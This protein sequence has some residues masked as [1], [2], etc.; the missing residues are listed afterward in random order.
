MLKAVIFDMDGVIAL[1][2]KLH[3]L[4]MKNM[5][6]ELYKIN[7]DENFFNTFIGKSE[8]DTWKGILDKYRIRAHISDLM[9]TRVMYIISEIDKSIVPSSGLIPLLDDLCRHNIII[10]LASSTERIVVEHILS[11]LELTRYFK[12]IS[13]GD[14]VKQKKPAPDLYLLTMKKLNISASYAIAIED[15]PSGITAAKKAGLK[16][17]ALLSTYKKEKLANAGLVV[18]SLTD[19]NYEKIRLLS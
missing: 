7:L 8:E 18:D 10:G 19:L 1:T 12:T 6:S 9:K 3:F 4:S 16:C 11:K 5:L 15:S 17:I 2:E 13:C 14:E